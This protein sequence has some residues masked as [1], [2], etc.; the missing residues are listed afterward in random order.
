MSDANTRP[1]ALLCE[2]EQCG[3]PLVC[4]ICETCPE[5]CNTAGDP[6]ACWEAY[7]ARRLGQGDP[8]LG[9][10]ATATQPFPEHVPAPKPRRTF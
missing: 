3:K 1:D 8:T 7:E 5:H 4:F 9:E 2:H 6:D 10:D